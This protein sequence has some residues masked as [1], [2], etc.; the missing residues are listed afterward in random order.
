[1]SDIYKRYEGLA[2]AAKLYPGYAEFNVAPPVQHAAGQA[3]TGQPIAQG[4]SGG[5][6]G[7]ASPIPELWITSYAMSGLLI[8]DVTGK[9]AREIA[10]HE[11]A[12]RLADGLEDKIQVAMKAHPG[13]LNID[14][15]RYEVQ[16]HIHT[17][18]EFE[19][20]VRAEAK[21]LLENALS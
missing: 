7:P 3:S 18:K 14:A 9:K 15:V 5:I 17:R 2:A 21:K 16:F 4:V 10:A 19:Q 20:A 8:R 1:M 13:S 12:R 11:L 6:Q